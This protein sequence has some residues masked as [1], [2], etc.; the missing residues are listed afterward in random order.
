MGLAKSLSREDIDEMDAMGCPEC[1]RV[2]VRGEWR[3]GSGPAHRREDFCP[4][5]GTPTG[6]ATVA[7]SADIFSVAACQGGSSE[8]RELSNV[9]RILLCRYVKQYPGAGPIRLLTLFSDRCAL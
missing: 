8:R 2:P 4:R 5:H 1:L 7:L 6:V 3:C 9:S